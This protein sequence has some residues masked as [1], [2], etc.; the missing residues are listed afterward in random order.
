MRLLI[1]DL[2]RRNAAVAPGRRA[3]ALGDR[4]LS[5]GELNAAGNRMA[6]ALRGLGIGRGDRVVCW[7]DTSLDVLPLFV[8][9]AKRG[10]VF[11]PLAAGLGRIDG[12]SKV[13]SRRAVNQPGQKALGDH[14]S[15][16]L[17]GDFLSIGAGIR[18][19]ARPLDPCHR[20]LQ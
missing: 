8:G 12:G 15:G 6:G 3:A 14:L 4:E 2:F 17:R 13:R 10:A 16:A 18:Q 7:A 1:G 20:A 5:H 11:A 9:L 19:K